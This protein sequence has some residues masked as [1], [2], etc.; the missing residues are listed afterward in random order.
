MIIHR[1]SPP[2]KPV[3]VVIVGA[4]GF[5]GAALKKWL[6]QSAVNVL[7]L[8]SA[9]AD[10]AL[11]A[12]VEKLVRVLNSS[13]TVI[14]LAALTGCDNATLMKNLAMMQ[15]V[16]SALEK[17]GCVH[18]V[19]F[20]SDAVYGLGPARV[21]E[22]TLAAPQDLYGVMHLAR[23]LMARALAKVP[24]LVF[25]PTLVYGAGDT[26]NAY[27]PNRF[28]RAAQKEGI[29]RLFG[30]GEE[31][32]DHIH[33]DDVAAL[34]ARCLLHR[35]TGMLNVATGRSVC[36]RE[37]AEM[38]ARQSPKPVRIVETARA[39]PVT[40]R[41]YDVTNLIKA[42]PDFKFIALEDGLARCQEQAMGVS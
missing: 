28:R 35:S 25:R 27:G 5:I 30:G 6:E 26:H 14:M 12:S 40:H 20:S 15:H 17:T 10:L 39:Q 42:F 33:V 22:E 11:P 41:H 2:Q 36:F 8:T 19:Y 13:D 37:L 38:V 32:R 18:L 31:T 21:T 7:S 24:V 1:Q 23:E 34:T 4:R 9:D 16:C 3:R 29:I